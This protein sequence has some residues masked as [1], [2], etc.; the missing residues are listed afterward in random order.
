MKYTPDELREFLDGEIKEI[1]L[2]IKSFPD[3]KELYKPEIAKLQQIRDR[4]FISVTVQD[5]LILFNEI[6]DYRLSFDIFLERLKSV[7]V[8]VREK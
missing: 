7:G 6:Q 4:K 3:L 8:E 2:N 5:A 1:N